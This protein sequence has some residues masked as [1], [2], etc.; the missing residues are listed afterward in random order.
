L[1]GFT[2]AQPFLITATIKFI[3]QPA[4]GQDSNEG[5]GLIAAA[6]LVYSGIAVSFL[7][8]VYPGP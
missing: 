8:H 4:S 1:I 7:A 6:A 5:L 3:E 2:F